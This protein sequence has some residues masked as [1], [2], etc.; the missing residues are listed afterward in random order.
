MKLLDLFDYYDFGATLWYL[1][2]SETG[3]P[4]HDEDYI[5]GNIKRFL[6]DLTTFE[7][8]VTKTLAERE[9]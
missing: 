8:K 6:N 3:T 9:T 2:A 1:R 4:V 7:L 5:L